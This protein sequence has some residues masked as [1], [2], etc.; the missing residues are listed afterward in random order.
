VKHRV[1]TGV[2]PGPKGPIFVTAGHRPADRIPTTSARRAEHRRTCPALRA[3][4]GRRRYPSA[5]LRPAVTKIRP[6]GPSKRGEGVGGWEIVLVY[7]N[8]IPSWLFSN[9]RSPEM[10]IFGNFVISFFILI[11]IIIQR[12][13]S[14]YFN[15]NYNTDIKKPGR[16]RRLAR[17]FYIRII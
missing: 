2:P 14:D 7:R 16:Q 10:T 1:S 9:E 8:L 15:H 3:E 4:I 13:C 6:F 12:K 17:A 5:G 11:T